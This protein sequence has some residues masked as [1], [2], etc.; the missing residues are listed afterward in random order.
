MNYR[1][2]AVIVFLLFVTLLGAAS[3]WVVPKLILEPNRIVKEFTGSGDQQTREKINRFVESIIV[4]VV[5]EEKA[6][7][8]IESDEYTAMMEVLKT[9]FTQAVKAAL[10]RVRETPLHLVK[11]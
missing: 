3:S 7:T 4:R 2:A 9:E 6:Q 5:G 8:I 10:P 1:L 11:F